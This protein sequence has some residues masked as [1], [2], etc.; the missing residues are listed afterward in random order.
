MKYLF[1]QKP[2]QVEVREG[3]LPEFH[4]EKGDALLKMLY[5]GICGSDLSTYRGSMAYASYP[6]VPGHEFSAEVVEI[7][8]NSAGLKKGS[9][10]T[11]NPYFNCGRCYSCRRGL[12]NCCETNETM[13]VQRDGAFSE[14]FTMPA[15]RLFDG[16]GISPK[17]LALVEPFCIGYHGIARAGLKPGERVLVVGAGTIGVL[18][19]LS[20]KLAGGEVYLADIAPAKLDYAQTRFGFAGTVLN[21]SSGHFREQ[22]A[23]VTGRDGFDVTVEAVGSPSTF[24]DC[25]DASAYGGRVVQIG[26]GKQHADFDFT[27]LQKKE[28][29]LFGSRNARNEDFLRVIRLTREGKADPGKVVTDIYLFEQ[30]ARAFSDFD[31]NSGTMLKVLLDFSEG[32]P[33]G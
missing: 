11:A 30:A 19:A 18:A 26:V 8:P 29:N 33:S 24:Q 1:I 28:L 31:R 7:A 27:I 2:Y 3:P 20:A 21:D 15:E 9:I 13:G 4:P 5:G 16:G 12:V 6:R 14:Y 23:S 10:V 17:L 32:T 22:V 25:V